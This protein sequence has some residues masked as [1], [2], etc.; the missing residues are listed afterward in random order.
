[1]TKTLFILG[2]QPEF[3]IAEVESLFPDG[4]IG[5]ISEKI[6][7]LNKAVEP[8]LINR[9]GGTIKFAKEITSLDS[10]RIESLEDIV[11]ENVADNL[12]SLPDGKINFGISYYGSNQTVRDIE[13]IALNVKRSVKRTGRSIRIIPNKEIELSSAQIFHNKLTGRTGFELI[14][15]ATDTTITLAKTIA[16]QNIESYTSRDQKR[17]YRDAKIG[18]LP[19]KLAQIMI[20]L[21]NPASNAIILD[22]FCG[23]GV[24]LQESLLMGLQAVGTDIDSRMV[25]YSSNNIKWLRQRYNNL[26]DCEVTHGD[27]TNHIWNKNIDDVVSETY[28]GHPFFQVPSINLINREA[29]FVNDLL[30]KFLKNIYPQIKPEAKL[31]LAIPAWRYND[32]FIQLPLLDQLEE[33]G[34]NPMSFKNLKTKDLIYYRP[35]QVVARQM[36]L[37]IRK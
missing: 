21:V 28:L 24:V 32:Q 22:P 19:P 29:L 37:L 1:M 31:C 3:G 8:D 15:I 36:L 5:I 35:N 30:V 17:P 14:V 20:N 10:S 2:R 34:Y 9:L 25:D 26:K 11:I 13:R 7:S 33:I 16:V 6:I 23:T 4:N 27:A 12:A 18:M